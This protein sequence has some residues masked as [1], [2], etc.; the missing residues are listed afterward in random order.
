M[1]GPLPIPRP[2]VTAFNLAMAKRL[3]LD[4]AEIIDDFHANFKT[5]AAN[6]PD[7]DMTKVT[8]S[9]SVYLP[10]DEVLAMFNGAGREP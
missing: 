2:Q 5:G 10:T 8:F 4:P 7:G 6:T 3:G 1:S 9:G